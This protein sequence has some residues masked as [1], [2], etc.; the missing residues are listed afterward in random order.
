M[1]MNILKR[2]S[3]AE[4]LILFLLTALIVT[5][6]FISWAL[7][8]SVEQFIGNNAYNQAR[9]FAENAKNVFEKE[10]SNIESIPAKITNI[11]EKSDLQYTS[12]LPIML[13]KIY[14]QL[15]GC[16][17][18]YNISNS[19][20]E[21]HIHI[22]AIRH[23]NGNIQ[24][25]KT[26]QCP[27]GMPENHEI[28][29]QNKYAGFWVYSQVNQKKTLAYCY[30]I[31][32]YNTQSPGYLK[33]DFPIKTITDI[34]CV[35]KLYQYGYLFI[36]DSLGNY[37]AHPF[38]QSQDKFSFGK[39]NANNDL[40]DALKHKIIKGETGGYTYYDNN[41][42]YF[43]YYEPIDCMHWRLGIVCPYNETLKSS[44]KLYWI[45]F[46]CLGG[47]LLF[48]FIGIVKVVHLLS[49]PL[50]QLAYTAR[51][52]ADGQFNV[53]IP[54]LKSSNE[55]TEL[56]DSFRYMQHNL[57]NYIEKL[58]IST[59]EREQRNSEMSLARRIQQRFLPHHILLPDNLQLAADLRQSQEVGGDFYE[60]FM[61]GNRLYFAI[62][63]VS[64]KGTPAA[65]YMVSVSKL[66]RYVACSHNSTAMICNI[67]NKH[68]CED[69]EDDMYVTMF[70][71]IIDINTGIMTFTNAGH[72]YPLVI[73]E[74]GETN[75]L[76]KYPDVP[77]GILENHN[78]SEHTYTIR[79]NN[80]L[81]FYTDGIT[82]AENPAG[83]FYGKDQLVSCIKNMSQ[84]SPK[85]IIQA[86]L[87]DHKR[88]IASRKQSDDLTLLIIRFNGIP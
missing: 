79:K 14:P 43:V 37:L 25:E 51:Q 80:S 53:E 86:I 46:I 27:F 82:D 88:H 81:L 22:V 40:T 63:D 48:L 69:A 21:N 50:K 11:N 23:P 2:F 4:Q 83:Q 72:P 47:G 20:L 59:A 45:I 17:L 15:V 61:L 30:P 18:H 41:I 19:K 84:H 10:I 75:F 67:I 70:M 35:N 9:T 65:L 26:K 13:M 64:G 49:S 74:N 34:I 28:L 71:G 52:I 8:N 31:Y 12:N 1:S 33:L 78:F 44:H 32:Q 39:T 85:Q 36:T 60:F 76:S 29:R 54:H 62:G 68:M 38:L 77:I 58:K 24:V 55:I 7:T 56:Y 6:I 5:F 87:E 66:F 3:F 42:K 16:S 57:V 73:H